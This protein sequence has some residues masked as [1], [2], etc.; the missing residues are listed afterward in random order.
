MAFAM[1]F[2]PVAWVLCSGEHILRLCKFHTSR[3]PEI[4][5]LRVRSKGLSV[6]ASSNWVNSF[7]GMSICFSK[8]VFIW[9]L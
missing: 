3:L 2:G 9:N 7:I 1:S 4:F 5:P 8:R 6:A